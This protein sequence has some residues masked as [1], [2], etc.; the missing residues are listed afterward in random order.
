MVLIHGELGQNK[1]NCCEILI[2]LGLEIE[3]KI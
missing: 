3:E 2:S 1:I